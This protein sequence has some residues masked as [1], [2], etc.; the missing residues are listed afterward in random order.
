[1]PASADRTFDQLRRGRRLSVLVLTLA[2]AGCGYAL[3]GRQS[4]LPADVKRIAVPAFLNQTTTPDIDRVLTEAVRAELRSHRNLA[5]QDQE[6][7]AD[8]V[9]KVTIV[10]ATSEAVQFTANNQGSRYAIQVIASAELKRTK[11][12]TVLFASTALRG[13][14][15]FDLASGASATSLAALYAQDQNAFDRLAKAFARSLVQ[16]ALTNF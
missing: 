10:Q 8:A 9:L 11:D 14:D 5:V 4:S 15:E 1:M 3:A 12:G 2:L 6:A 16:S 13:T 7:G